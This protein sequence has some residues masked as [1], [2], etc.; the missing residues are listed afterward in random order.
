[1]QTDKSQATRQIVLLHSICNNERGWAKIASQTGRTSL[2][3]QG[4]GRI[5]HVEVWESGQCTY[6]GPE[7][8]YHH[9][10]KFLDEPTFGFTEAL[11]ALRF[12]WPLL[13]SQ[14]TDVIISNANALVMAA[15]FL[16]TVGRT[17]RKSVV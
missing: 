1:M 16:R 11:S 7:I 6:R 4:F 3:Q 9:R 14:R 5:E 13:K 8:K 17:D 10:L 2:L 12:C 15:L